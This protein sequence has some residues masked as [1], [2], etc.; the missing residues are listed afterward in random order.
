[1][2]KKADFYCLCVVFWS[3]L[4]FVADLFEDV[5]KDLAIVGRSAYQKIGERDDG[6]VVG[7]IRNG[8]DAKEWDVVDF[9]GMRNGGSFHIGAETVVGVPEF[10]GFF[11]LAIELIAGEYSTGINFGGM[12]AKWG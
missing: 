4:Q 8:A 12:T 3:D 2:I 1:M 7:F 6:G 10:T 5:L 11:E 9:A